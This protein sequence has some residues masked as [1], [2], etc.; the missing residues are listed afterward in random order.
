MRVYRR[1]IPRSA[2]N[3]KINYFFRSLFTQRVLNLVKLGNCPQPEQ[4]AGKVYQG[5]VFVAQPLLAVCLRYA[6]EKP[7]SQEWLCYLMFI[8]RSQ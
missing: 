4:V 5:P 1:E 3:D 7:H 6:L 2:R 8:T